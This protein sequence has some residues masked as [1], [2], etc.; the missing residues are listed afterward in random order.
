[1]PQRSRSV[2]EVNA[3]DYLLDMIEQLAAMARELGEV[4]VARH[5]DVI[6][7]RQRAVPHGAPPR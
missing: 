2:A 5:L 4:S 3:P 1:M 7:E 6:A